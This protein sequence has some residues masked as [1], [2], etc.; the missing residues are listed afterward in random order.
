VEIQIR[1]REMHQVAEYGIAA[2]WR[3][4]E[5]GKG[6]QRLEAKI[7][8]LRQLMDWRDEVADAEEFVESLKSDVFQDQVYCFTPAGDIIEL[9][10]GA[11]PVDFAYRIHT[12]VGHQCVGATVN[13]QMVPLDYK[14]QNAQVV[15]IKTSKTVNGP[16]RDWLQANSGYVTTASAREKI[17]QWF[18]KQERD[19]N[20]AQGKEILE[21]ELRRLGVEMKAEDVL[22]R[23]PRYTKLDDFLAAIGYGGISAQAIFSKLDE[24]PKEVFPTSTVIKAPKTPARVEVMGAG[25][26][27]TIQA[28]CC[29]PV[30]GDPIIGYTTRG[31]GVVY[32]RRDCPNISN[33][34]DPERL[35]PVSW[36]AE[37]HE[38]HPVPVRVIALD[39]VG[40]LK[41]VS[42]LLSD[43]RVNILSVLTQTHDDRSVTLLLTIEV[44]SVGQL[45]RIMHRRESLRDVVEVRRDVPMSQQN[46]AWAS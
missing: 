3:Y 43:E 34:S 4:K 38:T 40:L 32:H 11:T 12:Q 16:R 7:T 28:N 44:E 23:F 21:R 30:P 15:K 19:E 5:G 41:D 13:G 22:K 18:R 9:P 29:R 36:G 46:Q 8:W 27:L 17:R 42:T 20:I 45:S 25:N 31:R 2:H 10:N 24:T 26:L 35:V 39:R 1:T 33:L 14:L 37:A 6:D